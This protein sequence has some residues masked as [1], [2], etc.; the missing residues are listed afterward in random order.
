[1][2][3]TIWR[4]P[5]SALAVAEMNQIASELVVKDSVRASYLSI[6]EPSS[7]PPNDQ[8]RAE[9]A[10]FSREIV[11]GMAM[12]IIVGEGGGFRASLVRAVGVTLTTLMP[13]RVPFK[14]LSNVEDAIT[15]IAPHC[16]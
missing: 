5:A 6:I 11:P 7:P 1:M 15:L 14:F 3:F 2:L 8:A 12:A 13:H 4:G 10:R 9:L 16:L